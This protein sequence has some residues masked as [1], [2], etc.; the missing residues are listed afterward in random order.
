[1]SFLENKRWIQVLKRLILLSL[2]VLYGMFSWE[3]YTKTQVQPTKPKMNFKQVLLNSSFTKDTLYTLH[4]AFVEVD[5]AKQIAVLV[6][7]DGSRMNFKISSG[8]SNIS[9]G[10]STPS[11]LYVVQWKSKEW[12]SRQFDNTLMLWWINFNQG[13]GFHGLAG[14]GYYGNLGVRPSSHGCVRISREDGEAI[15]PL[16]E[17]G[18]PVLVYEK[19][20]PFT[21]GFL[22]STNNYTYLNNDDLREEIN[23]RIIHISTGSYFLKNWDMV[24]IDK[25][26]V[27][28]DGHPIGV[29]KQNIPTQIHGQITKIS[30]PGVVDKL[31][32][33]TLQYSIKK[34]LPDSSVAV[35]L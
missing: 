35:N 26:N 15:F 22:D 28:S 1:M 34:I 33:L 21:I 2:L 8:N 10:I 30:V 19:Q 18:A 7:R 12:H 4:N 14:S 6:K 32:H 20:C 3:F 25:N 16:L 27:F 24:L 17:N 13:I 9:K 23:E 31:A 11:G 5:L 29:W